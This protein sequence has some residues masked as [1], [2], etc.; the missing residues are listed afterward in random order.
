MVL[1]AGVTLVQ[2][3]AVT[4]GLTIACYVSHF[5]PLQVTHPVTKRRNGSEC[6]SEQELEQKPSKAHTT[7]TSPPTQANHAI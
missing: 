7:N 1:E 3:M 6:I 2:C 5:K 4:K